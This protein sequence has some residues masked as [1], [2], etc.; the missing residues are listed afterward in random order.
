MSSISADK[1]DGWWK[2]QVKNLEPHKCEGWEWV[3]L[4]D[5][6]NG[7][8][9]KFYSLQGLSVAYNQGLWHPDEIFAMY[10]KQGK[11]LGNGVQ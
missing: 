3:G 8:S 11:V 5:F 6:A 1:D 2:S 7:S 4:A 9:Q 10:R